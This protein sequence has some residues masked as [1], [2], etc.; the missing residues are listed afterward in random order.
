MAWA[1]VLM[2]EY[3]PE[4]RSHEEVIAEA[5]RSR[6]GVLIKKALRSGHL[7]ADESLRFVSRESPV[8]EY[9]TSIVIGS[10]SPDRMHENAA[11]IAS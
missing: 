1:D 5:G 3:H 7:S 10:L 6:I 9:I 11:I 2:I 4:D 8:A